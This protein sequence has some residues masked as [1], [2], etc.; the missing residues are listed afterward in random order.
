VTRL[1]TIYW[2]DIPAQVLGRNGRRTV[3]KMVLHPRFQ[4][5]IDRAAMRAGRGSSDQYLADWRRV[6]TPCEGHLEEVVEKVEKEVARLEALFDEGSLDRLARAS[7]LAKPP[8]S[9]CPDA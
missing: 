5:A 1:I 4:K 2:R 6:A 9:T 3:R 7:G 8:A